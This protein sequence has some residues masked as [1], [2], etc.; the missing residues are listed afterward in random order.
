MDYYYVMNLILENPDK[1]RGY[2]ELL[3]IY[4]Q[5]NMPEQAAYMEILIKSHENNLSNPDEKQ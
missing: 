4:K 3:N 5:N 1:T 2:K